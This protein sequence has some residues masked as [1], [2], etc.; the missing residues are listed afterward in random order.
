M[1]D[2]DLL[3]AVLFDV[4]SDAVHGGESRMTAPA[5]DHADPD[6]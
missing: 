3:V 5:D 4:V 6:F 2:S 1:L